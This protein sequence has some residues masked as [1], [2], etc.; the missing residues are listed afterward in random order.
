MSLDS[1]VELEP[2]PPN[3]LKE[4]I[5]LLGDL[6]E[7]CLVFLRVNGTAAIGV[8]LAEGLVD[9]GIVQVH[10][11]TERFHFGLVNAAVAV[12]IYFGKHLL[13]HLRDHGRVGMPPVVRSGPEHARK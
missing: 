1:L 2:P 9:F 8:E 13:L 5:Q 10:A 4:L 3:W 6:L 12:A 7:D 11:G